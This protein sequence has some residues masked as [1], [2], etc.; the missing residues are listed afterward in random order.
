MM[1]DI[2][3][4]S[5]AVLATEAAVAFY[6]AY[7]IVSRSKVPQKDYDNIVLK[8]GMLEEKL[9]D[10]MEE[11][12]RLTQKVQVMHEE[13]QVMRDR[14]IVFEM[15]KKNL[16]N[17]NAQFDT[18]TEL[19]DERS[20]LSFE[21]LANRI[22]EE[23]IDKFGRVSREGINDLLEPV[24]ENMRVLKKELEETFVKY[25]KEQ[26]SL[27]NEIQRIVLANERITSQAESLASALKGNT[28]MQGNWGEV[29]LEKVL[30][31]SGLR[32]DEDYKVHSVGMSLRGVEGGKQ[33]P[34]VV[35]LLPEGKHI[36]VDSKV[37]LVHY[38]RYCSERSNETARLSYLKQF[39]HSVRSH[40][41][42]LASKRYVDI[43]GLNAPDFVLMF[44]PIESA[45]F[46]M[47][48]T[49]TELHGYAWHKK[50]VIVCPSTLLATL[51]T[52]ES[53]WRLE[54]Q[55]RNTLEIARQGGAL[56]DK[57]AGFVQDM[58]KLGR[59][60]DSANGVYKDAMRKLSEG[61]GNILSRTKNL[62]NLGVKTSKS[63]E[64][65]ASD[66]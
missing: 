58:Q 49:D 57:I 11:N 64:L 41:S 7:T 13:L 48:R 9:R 53:L 22:F 56:Y 30:E 29:I 4:Q 19:I 65:E 63:L 2:T 42:D 26:F 3:W 52:V 18:L 66:S 27:K 21:N 8:N 50:I 55:N 38:E 59:Q 54:K 44:I 23:K 31:D 5:I 39:V 24:K 37:S 43:D 60:I 25:G 17:I 28:K 61:H 34:D 62:K 45:Y 20:R 32:R 16:E 36:V 33:Y 10:S 47:M 1:F 46:L 12:R 14:A 6:V 51:K 40:V 35:I 15:E